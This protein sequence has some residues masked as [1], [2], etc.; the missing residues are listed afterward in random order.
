MKRLQ[1]VIRPERLDDVQAGL[2][3]AGFDGFMVHDIRGHGSEGTPSG[4]WRGVAYSMAIRH[5][6]LVDVL[7]EDEE[8]A[9]AAAAIKAGAS[10]GQPGDGMI[11]VVDVVQ[12]IPLR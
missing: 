1:A 9:R 4:E 10:T 7:V 3:A 8:V 2:A 5:K 6:M 12:V 11:F